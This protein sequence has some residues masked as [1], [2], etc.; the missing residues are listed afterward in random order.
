M[1]RKNDQRTKEAYL[2]FY[3]TLRHPTIAL[4]REKFFS[5]D[6]ET[7]DNIITR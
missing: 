2:A 5:P 4:S 3:L 1:L 7:V 6:N